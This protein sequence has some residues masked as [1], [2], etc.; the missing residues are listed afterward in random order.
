[1][2]SWILA[3]EE[4]SYY[5]YDENV[6]PIGYFRPDYT[7]S[8]EDKMIDM[9]TDEALVDGGKLTLYFEPLASEGLSLQQF[10][11]WAQGVLRRLSAWQKYQQ[12]SNLP[13]P[14][15]GMEHGI[16]SVIINVRFKEPAELTK[17]GLGWALD[18]I[19]A[20]LRERQMI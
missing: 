11:A 1:M 9:I 10:T 7:T 17:N 16:L 19:L 2:M 14:Q 13:E 4:F 18:S 12:E 8:A 3:R 6:K 5:I 20:E 15:V